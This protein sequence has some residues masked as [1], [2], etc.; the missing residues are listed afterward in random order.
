[1]HLRRLGMKGITVGG[2]TIYDTGNVKPPTNDP[3][4]R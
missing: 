3:Q 4:A 1:M 2:V